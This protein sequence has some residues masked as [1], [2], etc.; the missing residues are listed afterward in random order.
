MAFPHCDA[1]P[2]HCGKLVLLIYVA[3]AVAFYLGSPELRVALGNRIV[4][5]AFMP[6]PKATIDKDD[7][8]IFAQDN[9][10]TTG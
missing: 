3:S 1:M 2:A 9:I 7:C 6:M 8:T 5:A 10:G 4:F